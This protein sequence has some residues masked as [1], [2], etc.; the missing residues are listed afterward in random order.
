M[1]GHAFSFLT[2]SWRTETLFANKQ[3]K[4]SMANAHQDPANFSAPPQL[5]PYGEYL[6]EAGK[7]VSMMQDPSVPDG[8]IEAKLTEFLSKQR[9]PLVETMLNEPPG[10][11]ATILVGSFNTTLVLAATRASRPQI[12]RFLL[13]AP[14]GANPNLTPNARKAAGT[15]PILEAL[16][17]MNVACLKE[18]VSGIVSPDLSLADSNGTTPLTAVSGLFS[19]NPTFGQS[20][21]ELLFGKT[22]QVLTPEDRQ[23]AID[24]CEKQPFQDGDLAALQKLLQQFPAL[25]DAEI[26]IDENGTTTTLLFT[27]A[28]AGNVKA[29]ETL[30]QAG[31]DPNVAVGT[32]DTPLHVAC[33]RGY[34]EVVRTLLKD[35]RTDT[36]C[37]NNRG[38]SCVTLFRDDVAPETALSIRALCMLPQGDLVKAIQAQQVDL[39]LRYATAFGVD[40]QFTDP[41]YNQPTTLLLTAIRERQPAVVEALLRLGANPNGPAAPATPGTPA[42]VA[43]ASTDGAAPAPPVRRG[44]GVFYPEPASPATPATPGV[45]AVAPSPLKLPLR[46]AFEAKQNEDI[47]RLLVQFGADV[48]GILQD[49]NLSAPEQLFY[50]KVR[51]KQVTPVDA[52]FE[53][54]L[55]LP[56][57]DPAA[58]VNFIA[59]AGHGGIDVRHPVTN[60]TLLMAA[61]NG[62]NTQALTDL[63][64]ANANPDLPGDLTT[65]NTPLMAAVSHILGATSPTLQG[66]AKELASRTKNLKATD[67]K[68]LTALQ[69]ANSPPMQ[70]IIKEELEAR[71]KAEASKQLQDYIA[72]MGGRYDTNYSNYRPTVG[73]GASE[74][75]ALAA[76]FAALSDGIKEEAL[77]VATDFGQKVNPFSK[78]VAKVCADLALKAAKAAVPALTPLIALPAP[79][80]FPK[81]VRDLVAASLNQALNDVVAKIPQL[82]CVPISALLQKSVA[83][84]G[85]VPEKCAQMN[86]DVLKELQRILSDEVQ[87]GKHGLITRSYMSSQLVKS[88]LKIF[89]DSDGL[90]PLLGA[91]AAFGPQAVAPYLQGAG[92]AMLGGSYQDIETYLT[93]FATVWSTMFKV[94]QKKKDLRTELTQRKQAQWLQICQGLDQV[95]EANLNELCTYYAG[96]FLKQFGP[97]EQEWVVLHD[98]LKEV[99]EKASQAVVQAALTNSSNRLVDGPPRFLDDGALPS[100]PL[101]SGLALD[102][103]STQS[104]ISWVRDCAAAHA[105]AKHSA[106]TKDTLARLERE[107]RALETVCNSVQNKK[108]ADPQTLMTTVLRPLSL[109]Y[110]WHLMTAYARSDDII[111]TISGNDVTLLVSGTGSG[112]SVLVPQLVATLLTPTPKKV[113]CT[114][115]RRLPV[116]TIHEHVSKMFSR[117]NVGKS[118]GGTTNPMPNGVVQYITDQMM[119]GRLL[120]GNLEDNTVLIIDEAHE[121][122]PAMDTLL[123]A[124]LEKKRTQTPKVNFKIVLATGSLS[125]PTQRNHFEGTTKAFGATFGELIVLGATPHPVQVIPAQPLLPWPEPPNLNPKPDRPQLAAQRTHGII[126]GDPNAVVLVFLPDI[127]ECQKANQLFRALCGGKISSGVLSAKEENMS[128]KVQQCSALFSNSIAETSVT[129]P[130]LS[131]VIDFN[132][133][134]MASIESDT[135]C[136]T[137][138]KNAASEASQIQ[139]RGRVGRKMPGT[140][141]HYYDIGPGPTSILVPKYPQ[142]FEL[143]LNDNL[144]QF[145]MRCRHYLK[146]SLFTGGVPGFPQLGLGIAPRKEV[147]ALI[148]S[149]ASDL[150]VVATL[151]LSGAMG[152]AFLH[153]LKQNKCARAILWL[154]TMNE[155]REPP[156]PAGSNWVQSQ[157]RNFGGNGDFGVML[158]MLDEYMTKKAS[159]KPN[160]KDAENWA[161]SRGVRH[162][163]FINCDERLQEVDNILTKLGLQLPATDS[164]ANWKWNDIC[165]ALMAG[166][167][168]NLS[169]RVDNSLDKSR[170]YNFRGPFHSLG[171][172]QMTGLEII[173]GSFWNGT[174]ANAGALPEFVFYVN[175]ERYDEKGRRFARNLTAID[176]TVVQNWLNGKTIT[177]SVSLVKGSWAKFKSFKGGVVQYSNTKV[178]ESGFSAGLQAR[179]GPAAMPF[180]GVEL[181]V[182]GD[183][184][185]VKATL[186]TIVAD[187][188]SALATPILNVPGAGAYGPLVAAWGM[189][190]A[191]LALL[192]KFNAA[193][194]DRTGKVTKAR[195]TSD[196]R[197]AFAQGP[198]A[199]EGLLALMNV[200]VN[201]CCITIKGGCV[202]DIIVCGKASCK[203]IDCE[204]P[205][206]MT[207]SNWQQEIQRFQQIFSSKYGEQFTFTHVPGSNPRKSQAPAGNGIICC[208]WQ[209][210][211]VEM[212]TPWNPL[213][214]IEHDSNTTPIM[215]QDFSCNNLRISKGYDGLQQLIPILMTTRDIVRQL[216]SSPME[217]SPCRDCKW[218]P[219]A[220]GTDGQGGNLLLETTNSTNFPTAR[221]DKFRKKGFKFVE[222][223]FVP[224]LPLIMFHGT[225]PAAASAIVSSAF[226]PSTSGNFGA[227]VYMS[228]DFRIIR[229]FA[230]PS[231]L[232]AHVSVGS[233]QICRKQGQSWTGDSMVI[234]SDDSWRDWEEWV[235]ANPA[236]ITN[237]VQIK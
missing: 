218:T 29:I 81:S 127:A 207:Q 15:V 42:A 221:I 172:N 64:N 132:L 183:P 214:I 56:G 5:S 82:F 109:H 120:A 67:L 166:Y 57:H 169:A 121:Q 209:G 45:A 41:Q 58:I 119:L 195:T 69:L 118:L 112:K 137:L 30:L 18:L 206:T 54:A 236:N 204:A 171:A 156:L 138:R 106:A 55:R 17:M 95:F 193:L 128:S 173:R 230:N 150:A 235:I 158:D 98:G 46:A 39:L 1:S 126:N 51:G 199:M 31:A 40:H 163:F 53:C 219:K 116:E 152:L 216:L 205:K 4:K 220:G 198:N 6:E 48:A 70:K 77:H 146:G 2:F 100:A 99:L 103:A 149:G 203:D 72:S 140:Y 14:H 113:Y 212:V 215:A 226:R 9:D 144:A 153:A 75:V 78:E 147:S 96:D 94:L 65:G 97:D 27:S 25:N 16:V 181:A 159:F 52:A 71:T 91:A 68:G 148:P 60:A 105:K 223:A 167:W 80:L 123:I 44:R 101:I 89:S 229:A 93:P 76:V 110:N 143:L 62:T 178:I 210:V 135:N 232:R 85:S 141:I 189:P 23:N 188:L 160:S 139:R 231:I 233:T 162:Y 32:G 19:T 36:M 192:A 228:R 108:W 184:V 21:S 122:S 83:A 73:A 92:G 59:N 165:D 43:T 202:R 142:S 185:T 129:I 154:A 211:E 117:N 74:T 196:L 197:Q 24:L 34:M 90:T 33:Y 87:Q 225:S 50:R 124:A 177:H 227:G 79:Q 234:S 180:I 28:R 182:T 61:V 10:V 194:A 170:D 164:Y 22:Q 191:N 37:I 3:P 217:T 168:Q 115:P 88:S 130:K 208:Y 157:V 200:L 136:R 186:E 35:P 111:K 187:I 8:A 201:D 222:Q 20:A 13:Q 213:S 84:A 102:V 63:L 190:P 104:L 134:M 125:G 7:I 175:L 12:I 49:V 38:E 133:N 86:E 26:I 151:N 47:G 176:K 66:I 131:H 107:L 11:D 114:Q 161:K 179:A 224:G 174:V 237:I 145:E 155:S